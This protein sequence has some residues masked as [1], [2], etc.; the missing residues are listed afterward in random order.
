MQLSLADI[1]LDRTWIS[2]T[3]VLAANFLS[4]ATHSLR[5]HDSLT[6]YDNNEN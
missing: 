5:P 4:S 6:D 2:E 3:I 1:C